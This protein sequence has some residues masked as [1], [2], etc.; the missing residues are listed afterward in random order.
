M[1]KTFVTIA[2]LCMLLMQMKAQVHITV[3]DA[4]YAGTGDSLAFWARTNTHGT[5]PLE[6]SNVL[7][8]RLQ[9]DFK[10][11]DAV[12]AIK[13]VENV[14]LSSPFTG[15]AKVIPD[16]L[17]AEIA[18]KSLKLD[19]GLKAKE[20]DFNGLSVSNGDVSYSGNSRTIPGYSLQLSPVALPFTNNRLWFNCTYGDYFFN[21]V[22]YIKGTKLHNNE[23]FLRY[24]FSPRLSAKIGL[25]DWGMWGGENQPGGFRNYIRIITGMRGGSDASLGDQVNILGNH[26][27][28][29]YLRVQY[30]SSDWSL[31]FTKDTMHDDG[32]GMRWKNF[33]DGVW[34][35]HLDR[36]NK[37]S[38]VSDIVGEFIHTKCQ[39]GR[40]HDR[41]ATE[42]ELARQDSE[43]WHYGRVLIGGKDDYFNHGG[44]T[45]GWTLFGQTIGLPLITPCEPDGN[46]ITPGVRNNR[47]CGF[48]LGIGGKIAHAAPYRLLATFT[49]NFGTYDNEYESARHELSLA[50]TGE[51]PQFASFPIAVTY[52]LYA[53]RGTL[54]RNCLTFRIGLRY[55]IL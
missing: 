23:L 51:T 42:E 54:Y 40:Y 47:L 18:R 37:D 17:Y 44:Y 27:G 7:G 53:D 52:G 34:T 28:R 16:E 19:I 6:N 55:N 22:R 14:V 12:I 2:A 38:W 29:T 8:V 21:D 35:L 4:C 48:H 3:Y 39:S 33:P 10:P 1:K 46:G 50:L 13:A 30:N 41:P 9:E 25:E 49:N 5:V 11:A 15:T 24:D 36:K 26:L 20:T 45:N 43:L 32:S 31:S